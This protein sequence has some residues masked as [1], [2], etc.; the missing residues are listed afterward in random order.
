[1]NTYQDWID[2][3]HRTEISDEHKGMLC[4]HDFTASQMGCM[5][6][7][8][9]FA[10]DFHAANYTDA[11]VLQMYEVFAQL[12]NGELSQVG[13]NQYVVLR[14]FFSYQASIGYDEYPNV[15]GLR[16]DPPSHDSLPSQWL[17]SFVTQQFTVDK[18]GHWHSHVHG[19]LCQLA[20]HLAYTQN[21]DAIEQLFANVSNTLDRHVEA[22]ISLLALVGL[23]IIVGEL[24]VSPLVSVEIKHLAVGHLARLLT[25]SHPLIYLRAAS[26]IALSE[27]RNRDTAIHLLAESLC[28]L[29]GEEQ[30]SK[31]YQ[32]EFGD[33]DFATWRSLLMAY[34]KGYVA[35]QVIEDLLADTAVWRTLLS[36]YERRDMEGPL[37]EGLPTRS[38]LYHNIGRLSVSV[39]TIRSLLDGESDAA[40]TCPKLLLLVHKHAKRFGLEPA[41]LAISNRQSPPSLTNL[42]QEL[43]V[44]VEG[45]GYED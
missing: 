13:N 36:D 42:A 10:P 15:Y 28:K 27:D 9:G 43:A 5:N 45:I 6:I 21:T 18:L 33:L 32:Y 44:V 37:S 14:W 35:E 8:I 24:S 2:A 16:R 17:L 31:D 38:M 7:V 30:R 22:E 40:A 3:V 12:L 23:V 11:V 39:H 29:E 34:E 20:V 41:D 26:Y 1:M 19:A 25:H 4:D